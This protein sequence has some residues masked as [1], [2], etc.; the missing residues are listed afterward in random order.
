MPIE[1]KWLFLSAAVFVGLAALGMWAVRTIRIMR[2]NEIL[3][4]KYGDLPM[5]ADFFRR[6]ELE[7]RRKKG[8]PS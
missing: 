5:F 6:L 2:E 3:Q 7:E 4:R 8:G 1:W